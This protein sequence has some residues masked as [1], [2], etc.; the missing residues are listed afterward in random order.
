MGEARPLAAMNYNI[1]FRSD[2][3]FNLLSNL[4][5]RT[6][7]VRGVQCGSMEGLLQSLKI[8]RR[9]R[10]IEVCAMSG[11]NAWQAGKGLKW[12][13]TQ[14]L[15]WDGEP[16]DRHSDKY[17]ELL[18]E[19]YECLFRQNQ[20][21][22]NALLETGDVKLDH[23]IGRSNPGETILTKREFLNRLTNIRTALR[24]EQFLKF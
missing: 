16:L 10:Q 23:T 9:G 13:E 4:Y 17:Q 24:S 2:P 6:F 19:A 5:P 15:W 21:A 18:D 11:F 20:E 12:W 1:D 22:Q 14:T 3:P 7:T 8:I